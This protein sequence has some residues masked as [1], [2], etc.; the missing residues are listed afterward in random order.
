HPRPLYA[1]RPANARTE[2]CTRLGQ[3]ADTSDSQLFARSYTTLFWRLRP[4]A[5]L[6]A[7]GAV[8]LVVKLLAVAAI[9][10]VVAGC[11]SSSNGSSSAAASAQRGPGA[12]ARDPKVAA[13]LKKQGV[14]LPNRQGRPPANGQRPNAR[15]E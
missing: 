9:A 14:T 7:V 5:S 12:F 8:R 2:R 11:G 13:C 6:T 15:R 3:S 10:A 4:A 1:P